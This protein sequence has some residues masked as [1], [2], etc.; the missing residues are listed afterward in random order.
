MWSGTYYSFALDEPYALFLVDHLYLTYM[1]L[2]FE[3]DNL[4]IQV[5]PRIEI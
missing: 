1:Y 5:P 3:A 4:P 2:S